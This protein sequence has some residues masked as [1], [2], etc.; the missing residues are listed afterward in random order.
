MSS[1]QHF[2]GFIHL[3]GNPNVGKSSFVHALCGQKLAIITERPQTTRHRIFVIYNDDTHQAIFS[4]AP[5]RIKEPQYKLQE[6]MNIH[7]H[8][9]IYDADLILF[10]TTPEEKLDPDQVESIKKTKVP[11]LLIVNKSDLFSQEKAEAARQAWLSLYPFS[12]S[13]IVSALENK[14][15]PELLETLLKSLPEGPAYFPKDEMS[16]R[17]ERFFIAELIRETIFESYYDEIPY[18]SEVQVQDF[19]DSEKDNKPFAK[20]YVYIFVERDSQK[21]ILLGQHGKSI[22]ELGIQARKKIEDFLGHPIYLDLQVKTEKN[23]RNNPE[24]LKKYG[25]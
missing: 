15:T 14:G 11:V 5:G 12:H 16:D 1:T 2:S 20:I 22:K 24:V 13:F 3:F 7:A 9:G 8:A 18:S 17:H 19:K 4:D 21:A 6:R 23:W 25:Y 10:V